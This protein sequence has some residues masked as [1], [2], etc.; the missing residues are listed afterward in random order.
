MPIANTIA[1]ITANTQ[2]INKPTLSTDTIGVG[3]RA[4]RE[5]K[6]E[7]TNYLKNNKFNVTLSDREY[8]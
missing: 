3:Y 4:E 8:G 6:R 7:I 5:K 1:V 2:A